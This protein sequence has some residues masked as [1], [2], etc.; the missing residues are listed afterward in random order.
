MMPLSREMR[1]LLY[2]KV[3][4]AGRQVKLSRREAYRAAARGDIPTIRH[5]KK[6]LLVP[7]GPWDREVK[8]LRAKMRAAQKQRAA[9]LKR[10][11]ASE[12]AEPKASRTE[13]EITVDA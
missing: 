12:A 13:T 8:K 7:R 10:A 2:Y 1:W 3:P 4:E 6:L 11:G 5:G 9:E